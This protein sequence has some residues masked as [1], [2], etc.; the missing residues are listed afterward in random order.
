MTVRA[1][2]EV[3][4]GSAREIL[5]LAAVG[6]GTLAAIAT[7]GPTLVGLVLV[8]GLG[9]VSGSAD[10]AVWLLLP[11]SWRWAGFA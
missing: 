9:H 1:S 7:V 6:A 5:G 8:H 11:P 4:R 2:W 3:T 10:L